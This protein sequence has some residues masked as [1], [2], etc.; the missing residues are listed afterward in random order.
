MRPFLAPGVRLLVS[1]V[2]PGRIGLGD[3]IVYDV[4]DTLVCHRVLWRRARLG[5]R[6]FLT[7]GDAWQSPRAWIGQADVVGKVVAV[8]TGRVAVP[9]DTPHRRLQAV[10]IAALSFVAAGILAAFRRARRL[11]ARA[12]GWMSAA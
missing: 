7:R 11:F 5:E 1:R 6:R 4:E 2:A 9:I 8:A 12:P 10:A 3:V